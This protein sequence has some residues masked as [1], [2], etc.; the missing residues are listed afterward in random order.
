MRLVQVKCKCGHTRHA[1]RECSM[2]VPVPPTMTDFVGVPLAACLPNMLNTPLKEGRECE[3]E[4]C[5]A[6]AASKSKYSPAT[7][8]IFVAM[9]PEVM[10]MNLG[11]ARDAEWDM[12]RYIV[13]PM[14]LDMR[15]VAF[16][17]YADEGVVTTYGLQGVSL[18]LVNPASPW[19]YV[20]HAIA[21]AAA[22]LRDAA[23]PLHTVAPH[24][25]QPDSGKGFL[26]QPWDHEQAC[27]AVCAGAESDSTYRSMPQG[28]LPL[29]Q[30]L[31]SVHCR[32]LN[33]P[34]RCSPAQ[35]T[36]CTIAHSHTFYAPAQARAGRHVRALHPPAAAPWQLVLRQRSRRGARGG[37]GGLP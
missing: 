21:C 14:T 30:P 35:Q 16:P 31:L 23:A 3:A 22:L 37:S 20:S 1:L 24:L 34:G 15:P 12:T 9:M 2:D 18:R 36:G 29:A 10:S 26:L 7:T 6:K 8:S 13:P 32:H 25:L 28:A 11:I 17:A 33:C 5:P 27:G 4:A 19:S